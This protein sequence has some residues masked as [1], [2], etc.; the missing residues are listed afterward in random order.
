MAWGRVHIAEVM[1]TNRELFVQATRMGRV[2]MNRLNDDRAALA[3]LGVSSEQYER[4]IAAQQEI[5]DRA[6]QLQIDQARVAKVLMSEPKQN[7]ATS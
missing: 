5:N 4:A 3:D 7:G 1:A 6:E 2:V